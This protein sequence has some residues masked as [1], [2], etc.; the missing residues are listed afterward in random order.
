[1]KKEENLGQWALARR[2]K[3]RVGVRRDADLRKRLRH[4]P[5]AHRLQ[6][7]AVI[8]LVDDP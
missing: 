6:R 7:P 8:W 5:Q 3:S 1:M 4:S 2:K